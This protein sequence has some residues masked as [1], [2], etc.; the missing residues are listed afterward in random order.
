MKAMLREALFA[1]Y[2]FSVR[3]YM[4]LLAVIS[5]ALA[6]LGVYAGW[7]TT[8]ASVKAQNPQGFELSLAMLFAIALVIVFLVLLLTTGPVLWLLCRL[9]LRGWASSLVAGGL[10]MVCAFGVPLAMSATFPEAAKHGGLLLTR[11]TVA[12]GSAPIGIWLAWAIWR[13]SFVDPANK[14]AHKTGDT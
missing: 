8:G 3:R 9:N 4:T 11:V 7:V 6:L 1:D 2:R 10:L 12:L 5:A 14:G 13:V